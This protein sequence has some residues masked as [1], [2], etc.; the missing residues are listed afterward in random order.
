MLQFDVLT[1]FPEIISRTVQTSLL[2][3]ACDQGLVAVNAHD[4]RDYTDD[5]HRRVD[6]VPYG[7]GPG[8]VMQVEP[9][10]R[11]LEA[12]AQSAGRVRRIL[13]SPR[14][15]TFSQSKAASLQTQDQIVLICGRYEGVD[16]RVL[17][18]VDEELSIGDYILSGGEFAALVVID[19]VSRLIPGVVGDPASLNEESFVGAIHESP[20][21]EYPQYTR[22]REF[23]GK[24]VPDVL[25]SGDHAKIEIWRKEQAKSLTEARRPDLLLDKPKRL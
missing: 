7:G 20:L 5:K 21:L 4:I 2:G 25:L 16:E 13:L 23:R 6:D 15:R 17:D 19:A 3:K 9:L 14:G 1:I 24:I 8:M 18:Y 22:P 10:V 12:V 11:G